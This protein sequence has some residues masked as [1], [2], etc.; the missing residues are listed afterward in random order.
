M[1]M[2]FSNRVRTAECVSPGHPDKYMDRLADA[3]L[4][5]VIREDSSLTLAQAKKAGCRVA[6]EGVAKDNLVVLA[7]E[8]SMRGIE[9]Q[10]KIDVR[11]IARE[12]WRKTGYGDGNDL[13][14]MDHIQTQ[15]IELNQAQNEF[16]GAGDQGV[17]VG[18]ATD[19]TDAFLPLE[20]LLSRQMIARAMLCRESGPDAPEEDRIDWIRSD[21]KTQVTLDANGKVRS[22]IVA[23]QHAD[24]AEVVQDLGNIRVMR[25]EAKEIVKRKIVFP[26]IKDH[27]PEGVSLEDVRVSVNGA[28]SFVIGGPPG[29]AGEVGRKIVVDAYGPRVPVGGGAY[30]GKD[31]TKVDRSAAYMA[32]H[33][34]KSIVKNGIGDAKECLVHIAYG[35]GLVEPEMV[36]AI[37]DKGEDLGDWAREHFSFAPWS[38]IE[39]L[40]LWKPEGWNYEE[41]STYGHYGRE[42]YPWEQVPT[43]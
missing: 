19:E 2:A 35:I 40:G 37:T 1:H 42:N 11:N 5:R 38:V 17:M 12:V 6:I 9:D 4:D 23:V 21:A 30:S 15:S 24:V 28:G 43:F 36:T 41:L 26:V 18:Y 7:G 34:A 3:I 27:L 33:V 25:E 22:V 13:I 10:L 29:D 16:N 20:Y 31:P 8:L 14:V 39:R 32:R